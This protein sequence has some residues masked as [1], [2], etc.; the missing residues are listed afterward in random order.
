MYF[1]K[2]FYGGCWRIHVCVFPS[3]FLWDKDFAVV[4]CLPYFRLKSFVGSVWAVLKLLFCIKSCSLRLYCWVGRMMM[5]FHLSAH[6][7]VASLFRSLDWMLLLVLA[8]CFALFGLDWVLLFFCSVFIR[9]AT[10]CLYMSLSEERSFCIAVSASN[11]RSYIQFFCF[12]C[13]LYFRPFCSRVISH[14]V[15]GMSVLFITL[16]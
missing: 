11:A 12:V 5:E 7:I 16:G 14:L 6:M 10:M 8:S 4:Y 15:N 1:R 9:S 13:K 3:W 2:A